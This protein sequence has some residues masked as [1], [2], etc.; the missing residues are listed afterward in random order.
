MH[1]M[2]MGGPR[3]AHTV[4]TRPWAFA[5]LLAAIPLCTGL[6][7]CG[8]ADSVIEPQSIASV[9]ITSA[10]CSFDALGLTLQLSAVARDEDGQS[11]AGASFT[12]AS[13]DAA[14][15]SMSGNTVTAASNGT[16]TVTATADSRSGTISCTVEQV[17]TQL[18]LST[19]PA[20]GLAEQPL[21][22]QPTIEVRDANGHVV[23]NDNATV[24]TVAI[25]TN[26]GGV[27]LGGTTA[28]TAV[29]GVASFTDL[30]ID[31]AAEGCTLTVSADGLTGATSAAF[32]VAVNVATVEVTPVDVTLTAL[33][34]QAALTAT[35]KSPSG[36]EVAGLTFDWSSSEE[37][38]ATVSGGGEVTAIG[39]GTASI[40]ASFDAI[41]SDPTSVTVQQEPAQ[42]AFGTEPVGG[43]AEEPLAT[44]PVTEVQDANGNV[45]TIDNATVV[46]TAIG[47]NPSGGA[48]GGTTSATAVSGVASFTNLTIDKAGDN[49][50]LTA[51]ASGVTG[52]TSAAFDIDVNVHSIDCSPAT[53]ELHSLN[54][55]STL[56]AVAR[57]PSGAAQDGVTFDWSSSDESVVT[58][59]S[60]GVVKAVANG[61]ATVSATAEGVS[62]DCDVTVE[63]VAAQLTVS[64]HFKVLAVAE[65]VDATVAAADA[66]GSDI[67]TPTVDVVSRDAGVASVVPGPPVS[68]TGQAPGVTDIVLTSGS[69]VDSAR[70]A[71]VSQSGF[72]MLVSTSS[73]EFQIDATPGS[74]LVLSFWMER[75][76]GG[77]GDIASISGTLQWDAAQLTYES[78]TI[79]ESSWSWFPNET[80]VN[81]GSLGFATFSAAGTAGSFEL[82]RVTFTVS[83]A[84][85]GSTAVTSSLT[86][87]GNALGS[88]ILASMQV[89][90]SLVLIP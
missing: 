75:P 26:P 40:T 79:V 15:V 73:D 18:A 39:N 82:A 65:A 83:G 48:L 30:T 62:G 72:A 31:K 17:A 59:S 89:V 88:D 24:V 77:D 71:V 1:Q 84:S 29:S 9:E 80:N 55:E 58:V 19:E 57:S 90:G 36:A 32:N 7:A 87:A 3:F 37:A 38:V 74:T 20:G 69:A 47:T 11:V 78:S 21:G 14:V 56:S 33:G 41:T 34:E 28:V 23:S 70:V 60:A 51:S 67:V 8:E 68:V 54:Q 2:L 52:A 46:T 63:Q 27:T 6:L 49:Y 13:S 53:L 61:S 44:Q 45:V 4:V 81:A 35:A 86:A 76:S 66:L 43:K 16:A 22:T 85:G 10:Q 12:W 42:L 5:V 25:G 64:P 50:T